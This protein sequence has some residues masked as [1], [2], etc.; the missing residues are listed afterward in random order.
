MLIVISLSACSELQR[1]ADQ[2]DTGR[3]LT[4]QEVISGLRQALIIG[5]DSA[6]SRLGAVD[7][8]YRDQL[9]RIALPPEAQVI[10]NNISMLPGGERMVEDVILRIN[11]AA[12]DAARNVAPIFARAVTGMTIQ[13]GFA[14][15]NGEQ[16][17]ATRYL[18]NVTFD[19]LVGLYQPRIK[20]S[21]DM[22]L[23]GNMST[24]DAWSSL[25]GE[26]NR[27]AR[28][29]AGRIAN[30]QPVEVNLEHYL[31]TRALD[32]LFLKLAEEEAK[33]RT[34]PVARVTEL[35]RRVFGQ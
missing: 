9:V 22:V 3:P 11:R 34:D 21:I 4:Q 7:G 2:V 25:T 17:A 28:S 19:E 8:Y 10:T 12:E 35:L 20:Q 13:D 33:I 27:L 32:G 6:A 5:S 15:L 24:A 1:L 23:V 31:T 16:D 18:R 26:W 14:I 29:T 30:L